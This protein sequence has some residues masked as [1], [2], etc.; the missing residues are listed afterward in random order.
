MVTS[1]LCQ[2]FSSSKV[3]IQFN[4]DT[5]DIT[6]VYLMELS[7]PVYFMVWLQTVPIPPASLLLL[8]VFRSWTHYKNHVY[9]HAQMCSCCPSSCL[10]HVSQICTLPRSPSVKSFKG[11]SEVKLSSLIH[12]LLNKED[13]QVPSKHGAGRR[14]FGERRSTCRKVGA[15]CESLD[16]CGEESEKW[17][18]L[19][20]VIQEEEEQDWKTRLSGH[21]LYSLF[22]CCFD[23][24]FTLP[25]MRA[26]ARA[27][28][29]RAAGMYYGPNKSSRHIV[30]E[31]LASEGL[32]SH[33]KLHFHF[34]CIWLPEQRQ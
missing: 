11:L 29:F 5:F 19:P 2:R 23:L 13:Q 22:P 24:A 33:R 30:Y 28:A 3:L 17:R 9:V 27:C 15:G 31:I 10:D 7:L 20:S 1:A 26:R 16:I 4:Q 12:T 32:Y 6:C 18:I 8:G 25:S 34:S 21:L 14:E